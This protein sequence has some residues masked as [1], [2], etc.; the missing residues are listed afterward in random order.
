[1]KVELAKV[2]RAVVVWIATTRRNHH[3]KRC[4]DLREAAEDMLTQSRTYREAAEEYRQ[5]LKALGEQDAP[6]GVLL[7]A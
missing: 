3:E 1:M 7:S 6:Q 2:L 5:I 4:R